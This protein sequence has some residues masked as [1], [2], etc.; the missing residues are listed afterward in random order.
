M[1][2]IRGTMTDT[3]INLFAPATTGRFSS[4]K[5]RPVFTYG[6]FINRP[7]RA[8]PSAQRRQRMARRVTRLGRKH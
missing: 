8:V 4:T 3:L 1:P 6:P 7:K 2:P 5:R